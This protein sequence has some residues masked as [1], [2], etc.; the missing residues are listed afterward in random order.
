MVNAGK[1]TE[2]VEQPQSP[3]SLTSAMEQLELFFMMI[4][5]L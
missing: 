1:D 4:W 5:V 2:P 3:I